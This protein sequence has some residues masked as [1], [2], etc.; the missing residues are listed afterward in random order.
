MDLSQSKFAFSMAGVWRYVDDA[1]VT[2]TN[3]GTL[4]NS[5]FGNVALGPQQLQGVVMTGWQFSSPSPGTVTP[6]NLGILAQQ[7]DG[8]LKL[9]TQTYVASAVTHGGGSVIVADFNGDGRD[10]VF[11][12]AHNESPFLGQSSV[13]LISN[14]QGGFTR[15]DVADSVMAHDAELAVL[16][17]V[18]T[19]ITASFGEAAALAT[20]PWYQWN[21]SGFTVGQ[22]PTRDLTGAV[23]MSVAV[24]D[25]NGDGLTEIVIGDILTAAGYPFSPANPMKIGISE[26]SGNDVSGNLLAL[27]TP[28]FEA[29]PQ[30]AAVASN[31]GPANTHTFRVWIDDFNHDGR[32][33]IVAAQSLWTPLNNTWPSMLQMLQNDGGFA[34]SD[35]SDVLN[36]DF[37]KDSREMDYEMQVVDV[38][39]SG[40]NSYLS[41]AAGS[42]NLVDGKFVPADDRQNNFLL[43]NDGTGRMHVALH[44]E[45]IA[46]GKQVL[47]YAAQLYHDP[48]TLSVDPNQP[49]PKFHGYLT[50]DGKLDFVAEVS[51]YKLV[52]GIGYANASVLVN[53]PLSIDLRTDFTESITVSDRNGS[54]LMRTFAGNDVFFDTNHAATASIDGGLGLDTAVYSGHHSDYALA[55]T[56]TGTSVTT[57]GLHDDL[58]RIERLQ[59]SDMKIALDLDGHAGTVA[60]FIGAVFGAPS[61]QNPNYVGIGLSLLDGGMSED[62]LMQLALDARL[63]SGASDNAAVTVLYENLVGSPIPADALALYTG[64]IASGATTQVALARMAADLSLNTAQIDLTGLAASGLAYI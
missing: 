25:L 6:V 47:A 55:R 16:G 11:L 22:S 32:P 46:L 19:V 50:A 35:R 9:Q 56:A 54:Q 31:W 14:A 13:A 24:A 45:F 4:A 1:F 42:W 8:T 40:I 27:I 29:R 62:A 49:T 64:Q 18:P 5:F 34:F 3:N 43:V 23:G 59:F 58:Q 12:A 36:P 17:G 51:T 60:K 26:F 37:D 2:A 30:Y 33:D 41:G 44:D 48:A 15:V 57:T 10:D 20:P 21:G 39:G 38:D 53:V 7:P 63:G 61:V 28:Y 52:N